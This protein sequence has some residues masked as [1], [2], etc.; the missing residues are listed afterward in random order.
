MVWRPAFTPSELTTK[1]LSLA[2]AA[3]IS[4]I[5]DLPTPYSLAISTHFSPLS[6]LSEILNLVGI[7]STTHFLLT[8]LELMIYY[9]YSINEFKK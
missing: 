8:P 9:V 2:L 5:V 3:C 1:S 6:N 7:S 4:D